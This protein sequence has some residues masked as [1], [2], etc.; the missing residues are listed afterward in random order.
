MH[1]PHQNAISQTCEAKIKGLEQVVIFLLAVIHNEN[2][3]LL[4]R[5]TVF[6][7]FKI[8]CSTLFNYSGRY[9]FLYRVAGFFLLPLSVY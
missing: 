3:L 6:S 1:G 9:I 5:N 8:L 2:S 4:R 7:P